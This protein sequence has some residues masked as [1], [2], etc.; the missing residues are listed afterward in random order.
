[1]ASQMKGR[2]EPAVLPDVWDGDEQE[3]I[4]VFYREKV[5][6]A[7]A[8]QRIQRTHLVYIQPQ[9]ATDSPSLYSKHLSSVPT[10]SAA[11]ATLWPI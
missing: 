5:S 8:K 10:T 4:E 2:F 1:M 3:L 9:T 6:L 11:T 7:L